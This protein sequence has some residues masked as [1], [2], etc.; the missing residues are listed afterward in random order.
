MRKRFLRLAVL[1]GALFVLMPALSHAGTLNM[2]SS[3]LKFWSF[4][5]AVPTG[6]E[7]ELEEP[8]AP[9]PICPAPFGGL[10]LPN[11]QGGCTC[12]TKTVLVPANNNVLYVMVSATGD[13]D[14]ADNSILEGVTLNGFPCQDGSNSFFALPTGWVPLSTLGF[15]AQP[16]FFSDNNLTY[17]WCCSIFGIAGMGNP[18]PTLNTVAVKFAN[19]DLFDEGFDSFVE[20]MTV[21]ISSASVAVANACTGQ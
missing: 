21:T 18:V 4:D 16:T 12:Y 2:L 19:P 5:P 17:Q 20:Q 10:P 13:N 7:C 6:G 3:Q 14:G 8:F 1:A 9:S 15:L 11:T